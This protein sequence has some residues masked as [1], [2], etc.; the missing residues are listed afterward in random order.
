MVSQFAAPGIPIL[1]K[2]REGWG[3]G[4]GL[5]FYVTYNDVTELTAS[6]AFRLAGI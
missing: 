4:R 6:T 3:T 2:E 1:R 5:D